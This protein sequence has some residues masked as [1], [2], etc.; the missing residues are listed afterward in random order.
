MFLS[1]S[2][3]AHEPVGRKAGLT[4]PQLIA[5]RSTTSIGQT[6]SPDLTAVQ[7]AALNFT[8]YSTKSI[9]VPQSVFD[10]LHLHLNDR[11][12]VE[13]TATIAAYNMVSRF[14]VALDVSDM[15][16]AEVP[17]PK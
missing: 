15:A 10:A 13:V 7:A 8:D 9:R 3:Q 6:N 5:I 17:I 2:R 12:M 14:L 11:Q 4:T 16:D 1:L